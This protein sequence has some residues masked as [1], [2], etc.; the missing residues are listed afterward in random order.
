MG[1]S[2]SLDME[3][4]L[5]SSIA[6]EQQ[7]VLMVWSTKYTLVRAASFAQ[8]LVLLLVLSATF[9]HYAKNLVKRVLNYLTFNSR[10]I[11]PDQ[12]D[13]DCYSS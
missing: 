8:N 1:E 5:L 9:R 2:K 10:P 12:I 11:F 7:D 13:F 6:S 4:Q 3:P